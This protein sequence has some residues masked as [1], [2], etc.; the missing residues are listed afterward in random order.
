MDAVDVL[1]EARAYIEK[2][3]CQDALAL[4]HDG[5]HLPVGS[6]VWSQAL[7]P[8]AAQWCALG[9][10]IRAAD[11]P[12]PYGSSTL[13]AR[14][15]GDIV[16]FNNAPSRTQSEVLDAFDRAIALGVDEE[17]AAGQRVPA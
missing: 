11:G 4:A 17:V 3:W 2:G 10:L 14:V 16:G 13:L 1:M 15:V 7:D 9:A 6:S 12:N 5:K 8:N